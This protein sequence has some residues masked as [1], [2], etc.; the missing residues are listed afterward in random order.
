[1]QPPPGQPGGPP[2]WCGGRSDAARLHE[3]QGAGYTDSSIH[4]RHGHPAM[5][6]EWAEMIAGIRGAIAISASWS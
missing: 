5:P 1:M 6:E 3:L 2:I 4:S